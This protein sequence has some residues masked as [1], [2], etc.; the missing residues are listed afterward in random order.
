M[1]D[2]DDEKF[3]FEVEQA[4]AQYCLDNPHVVRINDGLLGYY[5]MESV[6]ADEL[7]TNTDFALYDNKVLMDDGDGQFACL[8]SIDYLNVHSQLQ[9][10]REGGVVLRL[11]EVVRTG[12][13]A[14]N[15]LRAEYRFNPTMFTRLSTPTLGGKARFQH[16][17]EC[18][19]DGVKRYLRNSQLAQLPMREHLQ[20]SILHARR[21]PPQTEITLPEIDWSVPSLS[22]LQNEPRLPGYD[23]P[24]D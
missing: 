11:W 1:D 6:N 2:D 18:I 4:Y 19:V 24:F 22:E 14:H 17:K 15:W 8:I 20:P 23:L 7:P 13:G 3:D 12:D 5:L 9:M 16:A 10:R 21:P